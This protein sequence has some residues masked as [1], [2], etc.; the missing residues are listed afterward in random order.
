[1]LVSNADA[2]IALV[3][4]AAAVAAAIAKLPRASLLC[5]CFKITLLLLPSLAYDYDDYDRYALVG[6]LL[7]YACAA[8][9]P[10]IRSFIRWF[11]RWSAIG[12]GGGKRTGKHAIRATKMQRQQNKDLLVEGRASLT[13]H[14]RLTWTAH[15]HPPHPEVP[16]ITPRPF[17]L[18]GA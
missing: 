1:M 14:A 4:Y 8:L 15:A 5:L 16:K 2:A 18:D 10:A 12:G 9:N 17:R 13:A 6:F 7:P 11:I 3:L